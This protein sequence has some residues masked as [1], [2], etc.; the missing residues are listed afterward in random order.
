MLDEIGYT[1]VSTAGALHYAEIRN[2]DVFLSGFLPLNDFETLLLVDSPLEPVSNVFDLRLPTQ[3]YKTHRQQIQDQLET[4]K[5]VPAE[6]DGPKIVYS[7]ILSPHPPFVF[8]HNGEIR[9]LDR[10]F[11]LAEGIEFQASREEYVDGYREQVRFI[12]GEVT[13]VIDAILTTSETPPIIIIMGD[14]GP[15]AFFHFSQNDPGCTWERTSNL[16]AVFLPEHQEDDMVYPSISPVNTFRVIFNTYFGTHLPLLEDKSFLRFW[17]QPTLNVDIT[18]TRD[19][20][21]QCTISQD[22]AVK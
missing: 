1:T 14:H 21:N 22:M 3:T 6:I 11:S 4:L 7:H 12:N 8:D 20:H 5:K 9:T 17:Q 16:Y 2:S 19:S 13:K 15:S 10:P 18:G